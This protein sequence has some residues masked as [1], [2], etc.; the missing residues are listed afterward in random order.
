MT[1]A[2]PEASLYDLIF[3]LFLSIIVDPVVVG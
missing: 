3:F 1:D 2:H